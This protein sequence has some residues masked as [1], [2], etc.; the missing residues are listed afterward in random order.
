MDKY[1]IFAKMV[2]Y[3]PFISTDAKDQWLA[4]TMTILEQ[5]YGIPM[6]RNPEWERMNPEIIRVYREI[7]KLRSI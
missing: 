4:S 2:A 1:L 3:D 7:S 5:K 6:F